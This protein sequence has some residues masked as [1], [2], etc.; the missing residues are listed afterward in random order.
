[1]KDYQYF[2]SKTLLISV[3]L[4]LV[5]KLS[6]QVF[7]RVEV[8]TK[9]SGL[10]NTTGIAVADFDLDNDLD[11]FVVAKNDFNPSDPTT[12]SRLFRN[13]NNGTFEDVTLAAGFGNLHNY[14][15][16]DP[17][18]E[19]GV[20]MG[21]SWG[22]YD[23]DGFPDLFLTNYRSFQL[24][25]NEGDGAFKDVTEAA[26]FPTVDLCYYFSALW[27]DLNNDGWLD[28]FVPDW[29][30]CTRNKFYQNNG[31]GTFSEKTDQLGIA[32][33]KEGSLMSIPIDANGDGL[34]DIYIANDFSENELFIQNPDHTFTDKAPEYLV[35]YDGNDMGMAIGDYDN[36]GAFDIYVTNISE[37]RLMTPTGN[38]TYDNLAEAKN[39]FNTFWGW[40]TRFADFDLDG[41]EDLFVL[42]GYESD[43]VFYPVWKENFYFKN[44]LLE[45]Q[46]T[47][48]DK[49]EEA[50]VRE[51]GNSIS[52]AT[53]DYDH[54]GDLDVLVSN[55]DA[56]PFFYENKMTDGNPANEPHWTKIR[57]EGTVSNRDGLGSYVTVC[58]DGNV[59]HRLYYGAGFMSQ[60]LQPVHFGLGNASQIDSLKI[61]WPSGL[62]EVHYNLPVGKTI[63]VIE[64]QSITV[65][66]FT[67]EKVYG[68]TDPNSCSYDPSATVDDG[69]CTY[70][71]TP[72][73][74][75]E[76]NVGF[77]QTKN[78]SCTGSPGSTYH[79][80]VSNGE[81]LEGQGTPNVTVNWHLAKTAAISVREF[82]TCASELTE[83]AITLNG[84]DVLEEHSVARLWNE[85]L[86]HAI[87][88]DLARPTVHARNL[89]HTS[90]AMFDA[91]A[92]YD[93]QAHPYLIGKKVGNF[94][95]H[96][97][98][99]EPNEPVQTAV[100]KSISYAAYHLLSHRFANSPGHESSQAIFDCLLKELGYDKNFT[101]TDFTSGDAAAL[102][103]FI[104]ETIINFGLLDSSNEQYDYANLHYLPVNPALLIDFPGNP[105]LLDP[106]RWQP[107]TLET[108]IDQSGNL[109]GED[110]P[111]FLS[112]EWGDV[113]PF[114]LNE[115]DRT[116]YQRWGNGYQV[117]H[118]P[119]PPPFLN[120]N[121]STPESEAYK[122]GFSLV[123]VWASHLDASDGVVWDISPN[124]I[125]NIP[126]E[127]LPTHFSQHP[128]FYDLLEG[129]DISEGWRVNPATGQP[130][131]P[132]LVP[133]GDY[134]RV[135][136]EFWADG[137]DSETPPGHWFTILNYVND[138]P[139]LVKKLGG[140]GPVLDPLEWDVKA[141]FILGG[142]MH[143]A[144]ISAWGIKGW[145][146][147]IRP[148]SA[149]RYMAEQGQ[150]SD[151]SLPNFS[152]AGI[153]LMDGYIEMVN[154]GDELAG[155]NGEHIG[156]IK[157]YTWKGHN[158]I[159]NPE[160]DVAGVGWILAED[161]MPY[162]RPSFVTPPFAGY[163][164]GHSTYSRA[165]AEVMSMLTGDAYFP[166]G[167]GEFVARK[168]EFLVFEDGPSQDVVL[169]WA[170]YRDAS[171]QC[172]LS[173]IWGGIHPPA[174][175]I[176]GR[177]IGAAI[178]K[179]AFAFALPYFYSENN[180]DEENHT[181]V[182]PNP[183]GAFS[184]ITLTETTEDM[185]FQLVN[186]QGQQLPIS[187]VEFNPD[188]RCTTLTFSDLAAGVYVVYSGNKSWK[189]VV[190]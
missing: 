181:L 102:G 127:K 8:Q 12:W 3:L 55:T 186:M 48:E 185:D 134:G 13:N 188:F 110:T 70:L 52:M 124:A 82:N 64:N 183:V 189:V 16:A 100:E 162:Q 75:G 108:F 171:D 99:F 157:L 66:E 160:T 53:F 177:R 173:R 86:L 78:Y 84:K 172:S 137:P 14:N 62:E 150:S 46:A 18:W 141:Y 72:Q 147:Y 111:D 105:S 143:D 168:N 71:P 98:S 104:A 1:M 145:Y 91:W 67:H 10:K 170:T 112:P 93:T 155:D 69:S 6:G 146:D 109:I 22:D 169:Q 30:G 178:G 120:T 167:M 57:L 113:V 135:L 136:A 56:A 158:F 148:V 17:G 175:D 36:N 5:G 130:Y 33:T 144:A 38:G 182:F 179:E 65:N 60:S 88:H 152:P 133:R 21:A 15:E 45:G 149:I 163:V 115:N 80:S 2:T 164:S 9:L 151:P 26:G 61:K 42:N 187:A 174:D 77:L 122:W 24:F 51:N 94:T 166:G 125:G 190:Q 176:P 121:D 44:M 63:H 40:D 25:H 87:R 41:D 123:S 7:S 131:E 138:H 159:G 39:V 107:L 156:K 103:N 114:S 32:G 106:N 142:T 90:V 19:L 74:T 28:I 139:F 118:D 23:N 184:T 132:Q 50:G 96:F 97:E 34:W 116:S 73:I 76:T 59:Q 11:L 54:D 49:S 154:A 20:K 180:A 4:L 43:L 161:W 140:K 129:G 101:S 81:I 31:D 85:A 68:C 58:A 95:S 47:F 35:D 92:I 117:F 165:A 126:F 83:A 153:P 128:D 119:G 89:F 37:N 27:W 29:L 79:W